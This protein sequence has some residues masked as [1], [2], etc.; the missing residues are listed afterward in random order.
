MI[1]VNRQGE[2]W[3]FAEQEEARLSEVPLEFMGKGRELADKLGVPLAAVL[4]GHRVA[5]LADTLV[6]YGATGSTWSS[7]R[8][9]A[10]TRPR[11]TA[12]S[13]VA[14]SVDI[15]RKSA[16]T[17]PPRSAGTW[18]PPSPAR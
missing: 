2:V 1:D 9:W 17:A 16:F 5:K 18:P 10:T 15:G 6:A 4:L 12:M 11:P 8:T 3:I 7:T 13:F 14:W